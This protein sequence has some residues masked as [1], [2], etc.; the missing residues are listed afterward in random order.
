MSVSFNPVRGLAIIRV[1]LLGPLGNHN[2]HV[3]VDTGATT[4][5]IATSVLRTVGYDPA[6]SSDH[7]SI[8]TGSKVERVARIKV[9]RL[10]AIGTH[11]LNFPVLSHTLPPTAGVDGLLGLDFVRGLRLVLDFR[12]GVIEL[13]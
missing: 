12:K 13:T 4:T 2:F 8:T 1:R 5:L 3:A 10:T 7:V 11:R 9:N 6:G